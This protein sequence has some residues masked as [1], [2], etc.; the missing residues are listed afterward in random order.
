MERDRTLMRIVIQRRVRISGLASILFVTALVMGGTGLALIGLNAI[1]DPPRLDQLERNIG[2]LAGTRLH[3][4]SGSKGGG[5]P[6]L[7]FT[8]GGL[9]YTLESRRLDWLDSIRTGLRNGD[10]LR[11]WSRETP[12]GSG[13]IW[14]LTRRDSVVVSY[15]ERRGRKLGSNANTM[16]LGRILVGIGVT[17]LVTAVIARRL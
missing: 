8:I 10:T 4:Y 7:E 1:D 6:Y 11:V 14:Q 16:V 2:R 13:Q 5:A 15:T 3:R 9:A 12:I 17:A